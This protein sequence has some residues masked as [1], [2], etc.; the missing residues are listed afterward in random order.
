MSQEALEAILGIVFIVLA[1]AIFIRL[2]KLSKSKYYRY[3]F[4]AT[5]I[6]LFSF[7]IY[8]VVLGI[9]QI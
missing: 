1:L 2:K 7:G 5:G 3:I 6:L 4:I 9:Y 8:L